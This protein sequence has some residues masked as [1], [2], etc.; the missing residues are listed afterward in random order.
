[1]LSTNVRELK[2]GLDKHGCIGRDKIKAA[3]GQEPGLLPS[4]PGSKRGSQHE[5]RRR[6][7]SD[8]RNPMVM[9][10]VVELQKSET[11]VRYHML[12]GSAASGSVYVHISDWC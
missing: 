2:G 5:V 10:P 1:M 8:S 3:T 4:C 6:R 9:T 12:T 7:P 11:L